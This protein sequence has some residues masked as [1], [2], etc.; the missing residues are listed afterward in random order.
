MR[1]EPPGREY[2]YGAAGVTRRATTRTA[3]ARPTDPRVERALAFIAA[4]FASPI[5]VGD[6]VEAMGCSRSHG[7]L[8]FREE[9]GKTILAAL[10]EMRWQRLVVLLGRRDADLS[11]LSDLCGFRS[12]S[13]LR[14]FFRRRTGMSMTVWRAKNRPHSGPPVAPPDP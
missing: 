3:R 9:T 1:G 5:D 6:V 12:A 14:Q 4:E 8:R 11:S 13:A 7:E 2:V 10:E